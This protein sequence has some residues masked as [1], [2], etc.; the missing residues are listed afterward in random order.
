MRI[1]IVGSGYVGLVTGTCFAELGE[2]VTLV[3]NDNDKI[4]KLKSGIVPIYEPG[5]SELVVKNSVWGRLRFS[6]SLSDSVKGTDVIIVAVGT[7]QAESGEADLSNINSVISEII[8]SL[9]G[10]ATVVIKSTVPAGTCD[11]IAERFNSESDWVVDVVSNPEFLKEGSAILDFMKPDRVV[12]GVES[13]RALAVMNSLY[14]KF[15]IV[16]MSRKSAELTKYAANAMLATRISFMNEIANLCEVSGVNVEDVRLGIGSDPRIGDKFLNPGIG[17]GGS[18]FPKDTKALAATGAKFGLKMKL[19]E[20][21]IE[22]NEDQKHKVSK[23]L[24]S[25]FGG[26]LHGKKV[27]VWGLAFKPGTDD[28]R[29]APSLV[30]INDLIKAGAEVVVSD[31]IAKSDHVTMASSH[32]EASVG[33]DVIVLA[34]EWKEYQKP[35]WD[36]IASSTKNCL[37]FDGRNCLDATEVCRVGFV[38]YSI[39]KSVGRS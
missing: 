28:I 1:T 19:V 8:S 26:S 23:F 10:S 30:I 9:R 27:A 17:F 18:C 3:D 22:V 35:D 6:T 38:Y 16:S 4:S 11:K 12:I 31:P 2:F 34:T 32:Y 24:I 25:H 36:R 15:N 33:A 5:L 14:S 20:S 21:V 7:P 13:D 37:V 29:E 39:G